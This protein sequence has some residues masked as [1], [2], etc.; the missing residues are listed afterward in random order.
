MYQLEIGAID[1]KQNQ[2]GSLI[3]DFNDL[4]ASYYLSYYFITAH[5]SA[6]HTLYI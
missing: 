2:M 3:S 4:E 5:I 6:I 1:E